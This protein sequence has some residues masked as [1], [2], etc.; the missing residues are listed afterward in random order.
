VPLYPLVP[1]VAIAGAAYIVISTLL[2]NPVDTMYALGITVAGIPVYW[3]L[4]KK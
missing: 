4:N 1:L 2:G 3:L